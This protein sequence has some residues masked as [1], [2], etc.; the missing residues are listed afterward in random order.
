MTYEEAKRCF[1]ENSTLIG[2]P[3]GDPL[4]WNLSVGLEALT[5]ALQADLHAL[6]Q[7]LQLLSLLNRAVQQTAILLRTACL[8]LLRLTGNKAAFHQA[9]GHG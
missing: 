6:R 5:S 4:T 8:K 3:K 2:D 9:V 7:Q 1:D